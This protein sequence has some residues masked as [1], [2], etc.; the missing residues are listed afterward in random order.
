MTELELVAAQAYIR[1]LQ[2]ARAALEDPRSAPMAITVLTPP[3]AEADQALAAAGL[4]GNERRLFE[5][6]HRVCPRLPVDTPA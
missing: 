6:V 2:T 1:L 5:L 3:M 4:A